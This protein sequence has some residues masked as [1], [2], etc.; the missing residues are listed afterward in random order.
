MFA[1]TVDSLTGRFAYQPPGN[2]EA[3]TTVSYGRAAVRRHA[4]PGLGEAE[5]DARDFSVE[6]VIFWHS[7]AGQS[8][9]G[10]I[11]YTHSNLDQTI[12][13][14]AFP[15]V[16]GTGAFLDVQDS[17]GVFGEGSFLLT[18]NVT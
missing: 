9:T 7:E 18:P 17:L 11:S 10:G 1:I 3:R 8:L 5:I 4:P 12:N 16:R 14:A 15:L 2:F 6:P 13:L